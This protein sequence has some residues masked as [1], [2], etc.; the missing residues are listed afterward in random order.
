MAYLSEEN[1]EM[2]RRMLS[3]DT[4][5]GPSSGSMFN[6]PPRTASPSTVGGFVRKTF[7]PP[8]PVM[9]KGITVTG[10][11]GTGSGGGTAEIAVKQN[12]LE[13]TGVPPGGFPTQQEVD[14]AENKRKIMPLVYIGG[15]GL[16]LYF[17]FKK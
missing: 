6:P 4:E 17:L 14:A 16:L 2:Y 9:T 3:A 12:Q 11:T 7:A 15:A 13:L 1:T 10:T 8:G 5:R